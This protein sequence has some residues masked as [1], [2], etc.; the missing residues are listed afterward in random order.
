MSTGWMK[1]ES[2]LKG[3]F[4]NLTNTKKWSIFHE[5]LHENKLEALGYVQ[6][7]LKLSWKILGKKKKKKDSGAPG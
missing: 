2:F 5:N 3:Y 1:K 7:E 6:V 4:L